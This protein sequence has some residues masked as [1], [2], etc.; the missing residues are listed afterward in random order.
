[1]LA[2]GQ[3]VKEIAAALGLSGKTVSTYRARVLEKLRLK[4]TVDLARYAIEHNLVP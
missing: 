3:T 2:A 1:M 4:G